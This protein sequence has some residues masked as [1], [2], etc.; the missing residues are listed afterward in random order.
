MNFSS[1]S[2][3]Q[4]KFSLIKCLLHRAYKI[5]S[6]WCLFHTE[7][8]KLREMFILNAY[9][10][11]IFGFTLEKFMLNIRSGLYVESDR[12]PTNDIVPT[13]VVPYF[14]SLSILLKRQ[15]KSLCKRHNIRY[16]I[17]FKPFKVANYF[18]LKSR[19]PSALRSMLVYKYS[20]SVDQST[21]YIGKTRRH[22]LCRVKEHTCTSSTANPSAVFQHI[23]VCNWAVIIDSF[24]ILHTCRTDYDLTILEHCIFRD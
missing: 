24:K 10:A 20:C 2:P 17:I 11:Q 14:G 18:N 6:S 19:C 8:I 3:S 1:Y 12:A 4:W 13:L 21:T 23:C 22:L 5:A 15:I 16:R 7:V 9:L